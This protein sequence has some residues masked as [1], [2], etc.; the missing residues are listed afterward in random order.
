MKVRFVCL[1]AVILSVGLC[2]L[3]RPAAAQ[4]QEPVQ[5]VPHG[6]TSLYELPP[7]W[8]VDIPTAGTLPRGYWDVVIRLSPYGA[9]TGYIDIGLSNRF[10][11]GLSYGGIDIISASSPDWNP[12]MG[13]NI[14]FRVVDELEYFPAVALGFASQGSGPYNDDLKRYTFKS[15]GFYGIVSRSFYFYQWTAGGHFGVNYTLENDV[16]DESDVNFFAGFDATFKY[17]LA[18]FAEWDAALNDDASALP[19]GEPYTFAGRGRGYLSMAV[20]WLFTDN[21]QLEFIAKDLTLNRRESDTFSRE[22]RITYI[23]RF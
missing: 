22:V 15:R 7:R 5:R 3:A 20:K 19:G 23:D 9:A 16:D 1:S 10:Q 2:A 8:L 14:K 18:F 17:N 6:S 13:I 4:P 21:L 11:L 12:D